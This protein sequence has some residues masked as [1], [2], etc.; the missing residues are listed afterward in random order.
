MEDAF[1]GGTEKPEQR[2]AQ[3]RLRKA[4]L[5]LSD[6]RPDMALNLL[7]NETDQL[8]S[9]SPSL[10]A[11]REYILGKIARNHPAPGLEHPLIHFKRAMA[12]IGNNNVTELTWKISLELGREFKRRGNAERAREFLGATGTILKYFASGF[13][14][15]LLRSKY[16]ASESRRIAMQT[17]LNELST[18]HEGVVSL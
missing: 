6:R 3:I 11:E 16:L 8:F 15:D 17:V 9:L 14:D 7:S 10:Q 12:Q 5:Y 2:V 4:E 1:T 13:D 18:P